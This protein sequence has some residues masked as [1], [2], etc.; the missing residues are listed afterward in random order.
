MR[1]LALLALAAVV[2]AAGSAVRVETS[3][4]WSIAGDW[5]PAA[6]KK[7]GKTAV[8]LLHGLDS[9]KE[10]WAPLSQALAKRGVASLALDMR[11]HGKSLGASGNQTWHTFKP[12][13]EGEWGG[14]WKDA[15]AAVAWLR[16][17]GYSN[18]GV[19]GASLGAEVAFQAALSVPDV[20]F[21]GLLSP[22]IDPDNDRMKMLMKA[23]GARPLLLAASRPDLRSYQSATGLTRLRTEA[24]LPSDW[25][26]GRSG[27]GAEM[28]ADGQTLDK[29]ADWIRARA[30]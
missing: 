23:Y 17:K 14:M 26:G 16:A 25:V 9:S 21:A 1:P 11:G 29:I 22:V 3:D 18:V 15:E 12:G 27:H 8:V 7:K 28:F 4:G 30:K 2:S 20:K 24:A 13:P 6:G 10:E 19:V 5:K